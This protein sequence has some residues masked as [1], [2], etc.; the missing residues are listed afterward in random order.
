M[1]EKEIG[2][3]GG[4]TRGREGK[5]ESNQRDAENGRWYLER[6]ACLDCGRQGVAVAVGEEEEVPLEVHATVPD[7][8]HQVQLLQVAQASHQVAQLVVA[9]G[10]L[11]HLSFTA[12]VGLILALKWGRELHGRKELIHPDC[13][14]VVPAERQQAEDHLG[15]RGAGDEVLQQVLQVQLEEHALPAAAVLVHVA[16]GPALRAAA[17]PVVLILYQVGSHSQRQVWGQLVQDLLLMLWEQLLQDRV[18]F[19]NRNRSHSVGD[20]A[21]ATLS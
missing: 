4:D 14:H 1:S 11:L 21:H 7:T 3:E 13:V 2:E 5:R 9:R 16:H 6:V 8:V 10:R 17:A 12:R 20:A 19:G 15:V 18:V